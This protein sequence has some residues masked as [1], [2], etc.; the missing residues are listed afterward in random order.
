MAPIL[1]TLAAVVFAAAL[2]LSLLAQDAKPP[3]DDA[4]ASLFGE[5]VNVE[6]VNVEVQVN[7]REQ[8][9]ILDLGPGDFKVFEDGRPVEVSHFSVV[10]AKPAGGTATPGAQETPAPRSDVKTLHPDG[11]RLVVFVDDL[12]VGLGSRAR[13]FASLAQTLQASLRP[14]D[15]VMVAVFDGGIRI[16][17]PFTSDRHTLLKTLEALSSQGLSAGQLQAGLSRERALQDIRNVQSNRSRTKSSGF[18]GTCTDVGW[19][20]RQYADQS[21]HQVLQ[22]IQALTGFVSSLAGYDGRKALLYVSDGVP[23]IAGGEVFDYAMSMCDGRGARAGIEYAEDITLLKEKAH[24]RWDPFSARMELL[25]LD[26]TDQWQGLASDANAHQVSFYTLQASGL[27]AFQ[28]R[29][30]GS[31]VQMTQETASF[32]TRNLQDSLSLISR[33]TGGRAILNTNDFSQGLGEMLG[34]SRAYYLLAF[35][36]TSPGDGKIHRIRVEIDRP[37]TRVHYRKSYRSK[38][39]PQLVVDGLLT[40]LLYDHTEN[41]LGVELKS[42]GETSGATGISN[43]RL[44]LRVPLSSLTLLPQGERK[45][46]LFT[47]FLV[48]RDDAGK[49]TQVREKP[50]PIHVP[51]QGAQKDY[52]YEVEMP[53][54]QGRHEV[55]VAVRDELAGTTSFLRRTVTAGG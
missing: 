14:E 33:E 6:L 3:G 52:V 40:S 27:R 9:P 30:I 16:A 45:R 55:A 18:S 28:T 39:T 50:V 19:I 21:H 25:G 36:P 31:N 22:T 37:G 20:A 8:H 42:V 12:H 54:H 43:V 10:R 1:R 23:L 7:D 4:P 13:F 26:T 48:G 15:Q 29:D 2:P 24:Q 34:D 49:M 44:Q 47:V 32:G 5:S 35:E 38:T 51:S 11:A 17:C 46:G 53:M 41:P